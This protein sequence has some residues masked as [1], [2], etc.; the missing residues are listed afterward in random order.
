MTQSGLRANRRGAGTVWPWGVAGWSG[1]PHY[2][3][4][5]FMTQYLKPANMLIALGVAFLGQVAMF[6]LVLN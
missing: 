4:D 3:K 5:G 6:A 1:H 2:Q